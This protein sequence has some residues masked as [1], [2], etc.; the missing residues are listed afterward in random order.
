MTKKAIDQGPMPADGSMSAA[1]E[2]GIRHVPAW[3]L[4]HQAT[5]VP[6]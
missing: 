3:Q 2:A 4:G 5:V 6:H 1:D